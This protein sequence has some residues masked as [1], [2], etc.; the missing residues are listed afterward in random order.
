MEILFTWVEKYI[1][2]FLLF[3]VLS[4]LIPQETYRK[5]IKFFMELVFVLLLVGP[6]FSFLFQGKLENGEAFYRSITREMER[7][8]RE[9]ESLSFLDEDYLK[10]ITERLGE[11]EQEVV[12]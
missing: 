6:I 4:Y 1:T 5:Y 10:L 8:E 7:R 3:A 12:Q 9:A 2:I 11:T